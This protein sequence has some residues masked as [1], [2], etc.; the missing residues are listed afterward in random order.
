MYTHMSWN[1][2]MTAPW[3]LSPLWESHYSCCFH[4]WVCK[5]GKLT[6]SKL[7]TNCFFRNKWRKN[8]IQSVTRQ[9]IGLQSNHLPCSLQI[10][11]R[12]SYSRCWNLNGYNNQ[13]GDLN[14]WCEKIGS[15]RAHD[16]W[17]HPEVIL[18]LRLETRISRI[19]SWLSLLIVCVY[20]SNLS[21][22]WLN[23][24]IY[25]MEIIR[26]TLED[27][28]SNISFQHSVWPRVKTQ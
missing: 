11:G 27:C 10:Q 19:Q 13:A 14:E 26:L 18:Q 15:S 4:L 17:R 24:L 3:I 6:S 21:I 1:I 2:P 8:I 23:Y 20:I 5:I 25:K 28:Y 7:R 22:S 9:W 12:K 16:I